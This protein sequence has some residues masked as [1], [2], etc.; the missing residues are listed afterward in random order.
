MLCPSKSAHLTCLESI[1]FLQTKLRPK[2]RSKSTR[3]SSAANTTRSKPPPSSSSSTPVDDP[4]RRACTSGIVDVLSK[5]LNDE[6]KAKAY[7]KELEGRVWLGE[8]AGE[9]DAGRKKYLDR[10]RSLRFN[11]S[12]V[13]RKE[14][15]KGI[16]DGIIVPEML[17]KMSSNE[18]YVWSSPPFPPFFPSS[19]RSDTAMLMRVLSLSTPLPLFRA[20]PSLQKTYQSAA[21]DGLR[22]RL[23]PSNVSSKSAPIVVHNH[24]GV[25][26]VEPNHRDDMEKEEEEARREGEERKRKRTREEEVERKREESRKKKAKKE[27]ASLIPSKSSSTLASTSSSASASNVN[28]SQPASASSSD[29]SLAPTLSTY[30]HTPF[31]LDD[32]LP[33]DSQPSSY[34][35]NG[36]SSNAFHSD[37]PFFYD[38]PPSSHLSGGFSPEPE[39]DDEGGGRGP[40][41]DFWVD[42]DVAIG[43]Q[44]RNATMESEE[45]MGR[46]KMQDLFKREP[47]WRGS[48]RYASLH[49]IISSRRVQ[50]GSF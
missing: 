22:T 32:F 25:V 6:I 49:T 14:L 30:S 50:A 48:V 10:M 42:G 41:M 15:R 4:I 46:R 1:P 34:A 18:L 47:I 31:S 28:V 35:T 9:G 16:I 21:E 27:S 3:R 43:Q 11:V 20:N 17:S 44:A 13:D 12:K 24:K 45:E 39:G 19:V 33:D 7:G 37:S 5:L 23:L 2:A 38:L 29:P 8:G 26:E 36:S 40:M